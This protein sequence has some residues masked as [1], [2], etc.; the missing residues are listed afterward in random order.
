MLALRGKSAWTADSMPSSKYA[1]AGKQPGAESG[2]GLPVVPVRLG[3]NP[4][5]SKPASVADERLA[6]K[7]AELKKVGD[8]S[9][10][11]PKKIA[12]RDS[13]ASEAE[14][15]NASV[16][17]GAS[18]SVLRNGPRKDAAVPDAEKKLEGVDEKKRD[19]KSK[20]DRLEISVIDQRSGQVFGGPQTE[21]QKL[22]SGEEKSSDSSGADLVLHLKDGA[23]DAS[24]EKS[25]Q[26][27]TAQK[28]AF[29][30]ALAR[31]L[32]ETYNG[33]IVKQ[34]SVVLKDGGDGLLRLSLRPESLGSV[35][36]KLELTDNKIA[37]RI[38]VE[39]DE[40][41]KAFG[42]ELRSLEQAFVDGG[43]DGASIELA[44]SSGD[45]GGGAGNRD[46]AETPK[47]F[48]SER[49]IASEYDSAVPA[50]DGAGARFRGARP[51]ALIDMLA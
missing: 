47:P 7:A 45:T 25:G 51:D 16:G 12:G 49:L 34:A 30:D 38:L 13:G 8:R 10:A 4:A 39:T 22:A 17:A 41:L 2:Q 40:A 46:N 42:K 19:A 50:A 14:L 48:F 27:G 36:I 37:G 43:F 23:S 9:P 20:K 44:L 6:E 28:G 15:L 1:A 24:S 29:A 18:L 35:K 32:R 5:A 21:Q 26:S 33:D 31:E 11:A 3:Q